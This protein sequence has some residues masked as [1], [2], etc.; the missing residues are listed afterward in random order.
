MDLK[1]KALQCHVSQIQDMAGMEKRVRD[2]GAVLGKPK[3]HTY[4]ETFDRILI[5]R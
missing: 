2:R 3:G 4:A 5:E 1:L